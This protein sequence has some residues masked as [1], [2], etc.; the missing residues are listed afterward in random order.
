MYPA[1]RGK[2]TGP[3]IEKTSRKAHISLPRRNCQRSTP[4][5]EISLSNALFP[6]SHLYPRLHPPQKLSPLTSIPRDNPS[7]ILFSPTISG[8]LHIYLPHK[9]CHYFHPLLGE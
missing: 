2:G 8:Y 5:P 7:L 9:K 4:S 6:T 1:Q 3:P